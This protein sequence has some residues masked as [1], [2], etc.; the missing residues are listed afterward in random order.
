MNHCRCQKG[1]QG[2]VALALHKNSA[3]RNF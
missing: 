1:I 2:G 3:W